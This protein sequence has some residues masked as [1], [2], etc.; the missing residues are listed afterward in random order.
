MPT[1]FGGLQET[2]ASSV[3]NGYTVVKFG[4]TGGGAGSLAG[5]GL[6]CL[7]HEQFTPS[8]A[9]EANQW[10][11]ENIRS[12]KGIIAEVREWKDRPVLVDLTFDGRPFRELLRERVKGP[13]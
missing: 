10:F 3:W 9:P 1:P 5:E 2:F 8:L 13:P 12:T 4:M 6:R 7:L 11:E